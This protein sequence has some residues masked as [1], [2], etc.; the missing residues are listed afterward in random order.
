MIF[1]WFC[2][3]AKELHVNVFAYDYEGYGKASGYPSE[4]NCYQDIEYA[5][6]KIIYCLIV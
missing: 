6:L 4:D 5:P 3:F 2:D 1:E